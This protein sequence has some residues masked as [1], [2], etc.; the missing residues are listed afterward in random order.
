MRSLRLLIP[1]MLLGILAISCAGAMTNPES[2]EDQH[3]AGP[4]GRN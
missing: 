3:K 1:I 2:P 4:G